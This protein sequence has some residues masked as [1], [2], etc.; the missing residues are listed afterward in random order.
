MTFLHESFTKV[1]ALC[2]LAC[3][4]SLLADSTPPKEGYVPNAETAIKI[5]VAVWTP[6]YGEETIKS[7]KPYRATL[8][9]GIWTVQ[10]LMPDNPLNTPM[11]GGVAYI[12]IAKS[13]GKILLVEHGE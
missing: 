11:F 10:G 6:I 4:G 1:V 8:K 5:A 13:D 7:E 3:S 2:A 12:E 9:D